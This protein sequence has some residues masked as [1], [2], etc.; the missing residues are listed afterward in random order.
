MYERLIRNNH[1]TGEYQG[2]HV[3]LYDNVLMKD[4]DAIPLATA[5]AMGFTSLE[6]LT[7]T[8]I[9][10]AIAAD[11]AIAEKLAAVSALEALQ[12]RFDAEV[13][14]HA[15]TSARLGVVEKQLAALKAVTA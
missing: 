14:A 1:L 3:K 5:E 9:G 2:S 4:S 12:I 15:D 13:A 7:A 11:N 10:A 8:E 6:V